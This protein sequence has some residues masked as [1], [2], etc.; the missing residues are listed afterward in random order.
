MNK[1]GKS[2]GGALPTALRT[3]YELPDMSVG[4]SRRSDPLERYSWPFALDHLRR[5]RVPSTPV[6]CQSNE[7]MR[8]NRPALCYDDTM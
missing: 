6:K 5:V 3:K 1:D 7:K 8:Q 4:D 2:A